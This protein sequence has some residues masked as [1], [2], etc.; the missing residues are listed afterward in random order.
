MDIKESCIKTDINKC[1]E[2]DDFA[3]NLMNPLHDDY[4]RNALVRKDQEAYYVLQNLLMNVQKKLSIMMKN[5]FSLE[6]QRTKSSNAVKNWPLKNEI[7][8]SAA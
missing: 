7:R 3:E 5:I 4:N 2:W 1:C 6:V 8:I